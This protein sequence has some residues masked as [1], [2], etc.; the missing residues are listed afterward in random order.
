[1]ESQQQYVRRNDTIHRFHMQ[2]K[3]GTWD[4]FEIQFANNVAEDFDFNF[5]I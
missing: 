5:R 3:E 4:N 2:K 1:M